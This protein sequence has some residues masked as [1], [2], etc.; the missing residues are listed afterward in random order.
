MKLLIFVLLTLSCLKANGQDFNKNI[1]KD[2]LLHVLVKNL[3]KKKKNELLK[4]YKKGNEQAKEYILFMLS[5]PR[6]SKKEQIENLEKNKLEIFRLKDEYVKLIPDSLIACLEFNPKNV[7]VS[8]NKSVDLKIYKK[9][10]EGK[11]ES[12]FQEWNLEYDS[13]ALNNGIKILGWNN[14]TLLFIKQL[15]DKAN[16]VSIENGNITTIGFARSGMGK[17]FYKIFKTDLG[18]EQKL[19]Y[20]DSCSYIFYKDNIVLEY[21]GGA[22]GPQC[23]PD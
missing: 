23:F 12:I 14:D 22:I 8:T 6:S 1:D 20:N 9:L 15:L 2:S 7:L 10:S 21:G 16:F 11:N 19:E 17:Y 3:P 4:H 13:D 5:M 18:E